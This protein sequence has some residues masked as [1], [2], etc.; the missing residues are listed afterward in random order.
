MAV[1]KEIGVT[2]DITA[3]DELT[4]AN[5]DR[6]SDYGIVFDAS[7]SINTK[8][9]VQNFGP[10]SCEMADRTINF[11]NTMTT[12]EMQT[13]IDGVGRYIN[14]GVTIIFQF[15]DG[16]Y[17][18]AADGLTWEGF[19]GGG[20]IFI[21][22]NTGEANA[23]DLHT[24]QSVYLDH[25]ASNGPVVLA[26]LCTP[27][28]Y[29]RNL[30]VKTKSDA[31]WNDICIKIQRCSNA[32][33]RYNCV[34]TGTTQGGGIWVIETPVVHVQENYI[35]NLQK[36]IIAQNATVCSYINDDTGTSP[37]YGLN[38]RY[39]GTIGKYS[40]QPAGSTANELEES[41]GDIR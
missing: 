19:I 1:I 5:V 6:D 23:E 13:L 40:T 8:C 36:G 29:I 26:N 34:G 37:A 35:D 28:V 9:L 11:N 4:M 3:L 22:G 20:A 18:I 2:Q 27:F 25:S 39:A 10:I 30:K 41:G 14:A 33:V 38:A 32:G 7:G 21:Q 15:A 12:A 31:S 24:T 16:T 17:T